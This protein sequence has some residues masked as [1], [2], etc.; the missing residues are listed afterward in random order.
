MS[1]TKIYC[2]RYRLSLKV[3]LGLCDDGNI[4]SKKK[5]LLK[6]GNSLGI[7]SKTC[8]YIPNNGWNEADVKTEVRKLVRSRQIFGEFSKK[9]LT[10]F[11]QKNHVFMKKMVYKEKMFSSHSKKI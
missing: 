3:E 5:K 6:I 11:V 9:T 1:R 8:D 7:E 2:G 10:S 4:L